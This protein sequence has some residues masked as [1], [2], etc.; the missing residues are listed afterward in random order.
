LWTLGIVNHLRI[1]IQQW[2]HPGQDGLYA[3]HHVIVRAIQRLTTLLN[4]Y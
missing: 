2:N 1:H 4:N 3:L